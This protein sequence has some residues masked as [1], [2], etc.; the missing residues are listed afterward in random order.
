MALRYRFENRLNVIPPR[1]TVVIPRIETPEPEGDETGFHFVPWHLFRPS[2]GACEEL[3]VQEVL[4]FQAVAPAVSED[5]GEGTPRPP[6]VSRPVVVR[7][8]RLYSV[9]WHENSLTVR[10]E[11]GGRPGVV[12]VHHQDTRRDQRPVDLH[13]SYGAWPEGP[14][15]GGVAERDLLGVTRGL[16]AGGKTWLRPRKG[17]YLLPLPA[18]EAEGLEC[19]EPSLVARLGHLLELP[20]TD[21]PKATVEIV[22]DRA[23]PENDAATDQG[24][25]GAGEP[26]FRYTL[27]SARGSEISLG[28]AVAPGDGDAEPS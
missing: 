23:E 17:L 21:P 20:D 1:L 3:Q 28:F 12:E 15:N 16:A 6:R 22:L 26:L 24:D 2:H 14:G 27:L 18:H 8:G 4:S 10:E 11:S 19:L 25:A 9:L 5:E 13:W 7:T